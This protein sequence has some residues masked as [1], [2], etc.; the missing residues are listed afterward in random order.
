MCVRHN[1]KCWDASVN[2]KDKDPCSSG[3]NIL[4]ENEGPWTTETSQFVV[5]QLPSHAST[6]I[7]WIQHTKLSYPS[8]SP[9]VCS[10]SC[11][12]IQWCSLTI[13][14]SVTP[15]SFCLQSLPAP[16]SFPVSWLFPLSSQ[17]IGVSALASVLP[18]I[19]QGWFHLGLTGLIFLLSKGLSRVFSNTTVWKHQLFGT[20]P[21]LW[22]NSHI[23]TWLLEKP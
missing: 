17:S 13:S 23:H 2:K 11:P 19:I 20:Q 1:T 7:P 12:L 5:V 15:F 18:M 6:L 9:R 8:L 14:S 21:S 10:N 16:R 4:L 3:A 22:S